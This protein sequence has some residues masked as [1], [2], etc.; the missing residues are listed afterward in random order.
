MVEYPNMLCAQLITS[1]YYSDGQLIDIA[2]IQNPSYSWQGIMHGIDHL[3]Q[4]M[5][6]RIKSGTQVKICRDSWIPRGDLRIMGKASQNS[7]EW[8]NDL[9]TNMWNE[10]WSRKYFT[11]EKLTTLFR[12]NLLLSPGRTS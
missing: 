7:C 12:S 3:E 10:N 1:N 8:V 9:A 11:L 6:R 4:G 2:S 5:I